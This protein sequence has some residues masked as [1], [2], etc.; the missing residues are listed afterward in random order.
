[1]SFFLRINS[2]TAKAIIGTIILGITGNST[3]ITAAN[4]CK[5]TNPK[6]LIVMFS[7]A[8]YSLSLNHN[9]GD[10]RYETSQDNGW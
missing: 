5:T 6:F 2:E 4:I 7:C 3:I 1:M 10:E 9:T 8:K